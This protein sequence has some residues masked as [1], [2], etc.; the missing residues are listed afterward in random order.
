VIVLGTATLLQAFGFPQAA[1]YSLVKALHS[2]TARLDAFQAYSGDES[3]YRGHYYS[4]KAPGLAFLTLPL[5]S[6]L[7][8]VGLPSGV[9]VL[10]LL[11][12]VLPAL[13]L[14]LLVR[15]VAEEWEPRYG[16]ITA[17]TLATAT[18]F[19]PLTSLYFSH[20]LAA[21][22]GFGAFFVLWRERAGPTRLGLVAAAGLLSGLAVTTEYPLALVG[23]AVG[24]YAIARAPIVRRG[25]AYT[26]GVAAGVAPL[27]LYNRWAFGSFTHL[28]Y[29]NLVIWR[30]KS[31]HDIVAGHQLG[32]HDVAAPRVSVLVELLLSP[33]GLLRLMPIFA[34]GA[35]GIVLL[36]RRGK[37]AEALLISG[38]CVLILG[39]DTGFIEPFG[40]WGPGP[41]YLMP[42]LAFLAV[43]L[44]LA[45]RR[46]PL[47]TAALAL[48]SLVWMVAATAT[49][50]LLPNNDA[51]APRVGD[52]ANTG[53]WFHRVANG[54]F[55]RTVLS[56]AGLGH[57]WLAIAP[58]LLAVV[59]GVALAV[60]VT[61][62]QRVRRRDAEAA[63][64]AL[65]GWLLAA[66]TGNV[67]L[68]HDRF[69]GSSLGALAVLALLSS[70]VVTVVRVHRSGPIAALP[71]VPLLAFGVHRFG[72]HAG[73]ALALA[74]AVFAVSLAF[75]RRPLWA[76]MER[77]V[78]RAALP[79]RREV[80]ARGQP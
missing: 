15:R 78:G 80:P 71:A 41:R 37:K 60:L 22:I 57:G 33:R 19:L 79:R 39:Y 18:L 43:P 32:F 66:L 11:G 35:L 2:G 76:W 12:V 8:A 24:C 54:D 21:C 62:R 58:F 47:T 3:Y 45:Y 67:L 59:A 17:V 25:L 72:H 73:W 34:L 26:V 56:S 36:Y 61:E 1:H 69:A 14:F 5:Y 28:S 4:N 31:G 75:E 13:I 63:A 77:Q 38:I 55:T 27:L 30:G 7:H 44:A 49:E 9:H 64:A 65:V 68:R 10:S 42:M 74:V 40:G 50:P 52:I 16:T 20:V 23:F 51:T 48:V 6:A 70:I 46:L 29:S 53:D